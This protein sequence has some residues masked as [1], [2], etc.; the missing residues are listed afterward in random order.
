MSL[1]VLTCVL[2]KPEVLHATFSSLKPFLSPDFFWTLKFSSSTPDEFVSQ[3]EH[4]FVTI[5]QGPDRSIYDAMNQGLQHVPTTHYFVLGAGDTVLSSGL[6]KLISL[7]LSPKDTDP[8]FT[9]IVWSHSG[10]VWVP[11]SGELSTRMSCPHPG[12]VLSV[13]KSREIGGF[14]TGYRIAADYDHLSRYVKAYGTGTTLDAP[15]VQ[16]A[17]GGMSEVRAFEGT[18]EE[19]LIRIRVWN[20]HEYAVHARLLR[21]T[22]LIASSLFDQVAQ[23]HTKT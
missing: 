8:V 22:T 3:F 4:P 16:F 19:E 1:S 18:L 12:A 7:R 21:R 14:D 10:V 17:G 15:L 6:D 13:E 2:G 11:F 23:L 9:P 5:R 20:S